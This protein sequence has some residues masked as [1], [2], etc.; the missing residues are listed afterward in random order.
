VTGEGSKFLGL[1]TTAPGYRLFHLGALPSVH[2]SIQDPLTTHAVNVDR[3]G[4]S[5]WRV[6]LDTSA[7][8]FPLGCGAPYE[9]GCTMRQFGHGATFTPAG[10]S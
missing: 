8:A 10:S 4:G 2:R 5:G 3:E 7:G 1:A 6:G 9:A